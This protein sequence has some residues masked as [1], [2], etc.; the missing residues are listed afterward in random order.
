MTPS[1]SD[2][3]VGCIF[4][5]AAGDACG[6]P[7]EGESF[8]I[9]VELTGQKISDDTQLT[10]ATCEAL[11]ETNCIVTPSAIASRFAAWQQ[12]RRIHGMGA[13][14]YKALSELVAGG[15]WALVGRR[16]EFAAGNGAA[17]RIA[18]LA[19]C[20]HPNDPWA[21]QQIRDVTR[22]THH[23]EEAYVGALAVAIAIRAAWDGTW[24]GTP[25]LVPLVIEFIPDSK[26][27][28]RL[29]ELAELK[30]NTPIVDVAHR[31]GC[32]G[33]VVESVPLA[34]YAAQQ[35]S[36]LGFEIL[37]RDLICAG[38][39]TD[40]TASMAGQIAGAFL[41]AK[42]L[43]QPLLMQLEEFSFID[44]VARQFTEK[45]AA[46]AAGLTKACT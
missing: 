22:I 39:D 25:E 13:S 46:N 6:V 21:R 35:I 20:L 32:S 23:H 26:V 15:H 38:G 30:T 37:L 19:F 14:T 7:F 18:P 44:D 34:I 40:T 12:K 33:Y 29:R 43:P 11:I 45:L 4:G 36:T 2:R 8:P 16:G 10:L 41:G 5:G 3:I 42:E 24:N 1:K 9:N 27:R 28:D 31:F 17:M